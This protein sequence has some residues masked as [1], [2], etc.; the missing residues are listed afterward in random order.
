MYEFP[1][2][3]CFCIKM[4]KNLSVKDANNRDQPVEVTQALGVYSCDI[5]GCDIKNL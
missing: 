3:W 2:N 1:D 4:R 5:I